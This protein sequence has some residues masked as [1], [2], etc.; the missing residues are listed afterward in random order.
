MSNVP[1][2]L[3]EAMKGEGEYRSLADSLA[4]AHAFEP[5]TDKTPGYRAE[6]EA[7]G[8]QHFGVQQKPWGFA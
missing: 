3:D 5:S 6:Y 8:E 7:G 2:Q 4:H 1:D